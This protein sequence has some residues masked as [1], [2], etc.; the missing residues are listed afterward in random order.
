MFTK[1]IR[2]VSRAVDRN[3]WAG[4]NTRAARPSGDPAQGFYES[5][6]DLRRGLEVF[7]ASMYGLPEE[8]KRELK[9]QRA[10]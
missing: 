5:S 2:S 7:E 9:R 10:G 6:F 4:F 1:A 3:D 8:L